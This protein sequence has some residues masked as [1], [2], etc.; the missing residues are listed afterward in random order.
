M[1]KYAYDSVI[2]SLVEGESSQ[3]QV[4]EDFVLRC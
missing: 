2:V 1:I 3:G 4:I